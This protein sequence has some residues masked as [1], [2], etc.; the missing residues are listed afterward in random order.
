M[1]S[2][3]RLV[4][5]APGTAIPEDAL[6]AVRGFVDHVSHSDFSKLEFAIGLTSTATGKQ[7]DEGEDVSSV[8]GMMVG[9]PFA[10]LQGLVALAGDLMAT[11]EKLQGAF[12]LML[13]EKFHNMK[14]N[15]RPDPEDIDT[16]ATKL[17]DLDALLAKVRSSGG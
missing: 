13:L 9:P 16:A 14:V 8:A 1:R 11:D 12:I 6:E 3:H 4:E 7:S 15:G 10:I 5:R 2:Q 17:T